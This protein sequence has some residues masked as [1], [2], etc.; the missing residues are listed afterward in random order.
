MTKQNVVRGYGPLDV[1][2]AKQRHN[3]A[4]KKI[5]SAQKNGRILDI[6]CG[7]YPA[8]LLGANFSEKYGLDKITQNI[9]DEILIKQKITLINCNL[10]ESGKIPF[11]NGYFDAV[12]M[13]AV[14]EHIIPENLV[15]IHKEIYRVLKPGGI[16]IMTTPAF[17]T[18]YLLRTLAKLHL[19]SDIEIKDHKGYYNHSKISNILQAAGFS[20]E[21]LRFGYF[22]LFMNN[23]ATAVK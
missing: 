1:F 5:E 13:L 9:D 18:D 23:W 14:F 17:W 19:I 16:Y 4:H 11:E 22:E 3:I 15:R 8:F 20:K 2:L 7:N 12:T 21:G 6:G 10:E